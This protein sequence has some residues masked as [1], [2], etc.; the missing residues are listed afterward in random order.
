VRLAPGGS[1]GHAGPLARSRPEQ[2]APLGRARVVWNALERRHEALEASQHAWTLGAQAPVLLWI[3]AENLL[4]LGRRE[5]AWPVL[6]AALAGAPSDA[7]STA[8]D[9]R[10]IM[11]CLFDGMDGASGASL[12]HCGFWPTY[13]GVMEP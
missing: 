10:G 12:R 13:A 9:F 7:I 6:D 4:A 3:R 5:E 2:P 1:A 11:R 8:G